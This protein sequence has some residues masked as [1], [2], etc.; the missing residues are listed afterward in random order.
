MY[1]NS[2]YLLLMQ[3][4]QNLIGNIL[5]RKTELLFNVRSWTENKLLLSSFSGMASSH[6]VKKY[7][8][9]GFFSN[10]VEKKINCLYPKELPKHII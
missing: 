1:L 3:V 4:V 9:R 5:R 7:S 2:L 6:K 10:L 8:F